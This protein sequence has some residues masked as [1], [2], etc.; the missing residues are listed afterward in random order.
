MNPRSVGAGGLDL[1]RSSTRRPA[2]SPVTSRHG[3]AKGVLER[4]LGIQASLEILRSDRSARWWWAQL[5]AAVPRAPHSAD[6][7]RNDR[8]SAPGLSPDRPR[9]SSAPPTPG[10]PPL[11]SG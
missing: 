11:P 8:R 3:A 5:P 9:R 2:T 1:C 4:R 7:N 10:H 6:A